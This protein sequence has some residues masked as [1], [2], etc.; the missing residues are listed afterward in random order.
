MQVHKDIEF[1]QLLKIVRTLLVGQLNSLKL[2]L[3]EKLKMTNK[4]KI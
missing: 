1:D 4:R 2:K 3:K